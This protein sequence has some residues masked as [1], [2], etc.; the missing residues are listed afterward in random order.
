MNTLILE[1]CFTR[2]EIGDKPH[3]WETVRSLRQKVF[4]IEEGYL[5]D[6]IETPLDPH[7]VHIVIRHLEKPLGCA[8]VIPPEHAHDYACEVGLPEAYIGQAALITKMVVIPESRGSNLATLMVACLERLIFRSHRYR[9]GFI[10]L[11]GRHCINETLYL[12][13]TG[14]VRVAEGECAY[15][16]QIVLVV[17][18]GCP[19]FQEI[20]KTVLDAQL[21]HYRE[22]VKA[23][24]GDVYNWKSDSGHD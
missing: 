1:S 23:D 11:K 19:T 7:G 21:T 3:I 8:T 13:L 18:R 9:Y 10:V 17:D 15:G 14:A 12:K 22:K 4:C 24:G 20:R 16:K 5:A 2:V 6:M